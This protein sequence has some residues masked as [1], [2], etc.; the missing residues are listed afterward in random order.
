MP[1]VLHNS[2]LPEQW[3][4]K[5]PLASAVASSENEDRPSTS[6][7]VKRG[8]NQV[9]EKESRKKKRGKSE[10]ASGTDD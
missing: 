1:P 6:A 10:E 4:W 8:S 5:V 3:S 2:F 7:G 9:L